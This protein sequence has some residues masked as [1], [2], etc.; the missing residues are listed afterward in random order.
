[1]EFLREKIENRYIEDQKNVKEIIDFANQIFSTHNLARNFTQAS[2]NGAWR[3][4]CGGNG[5]IF[6]WE[7]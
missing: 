2:F 1:M 6:A 4:P 7:V 5:T 3:H